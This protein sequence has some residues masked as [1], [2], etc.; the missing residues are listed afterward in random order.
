MSTALL[1]SLI[2]SAT[3]FAAGSQPLL[4]KP[5]LNQPAAELNADL[6]RFCAITSASLLA[7]AGDAV[8]TAEVQQ[9]ISLAR[10]SQHEL[11]MRAR[12]QE[13]QR[14]F[15]LKFNRLVD[16]VADFAKVYNQGKGS[17]WPQREADKLRK[18]MHQIQQL[19]KSLRDDPKPALAPP[20]IEI[21]PSHDEI[22]HR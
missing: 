1:F 15:A 21:E 18:A 20:E 16:A 11:E 5:N 12:Q 14:Q 7:A 17:V 22:L 4:L 9:K 8:R 19:E 6:N 10:A 13:Q 3:L 2:S